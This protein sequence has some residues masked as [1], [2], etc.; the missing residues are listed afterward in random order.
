MVRCDLVGEPGAVPR[1]RRMTLA[2]G[3]VVEEQIF[4]QNDEARRLYCGKSE[5]AGSSVSGYIAS[6]YVDEI[7]GDRCTMHISSWFD[8]RSRADL[9][10]AA[11]RFET[12]YQ[13]IF[14]GFRNYFS[15]AASD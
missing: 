9:P 15:K 14:N 3:I 1:T 10:P 8:V 5:P 4:Y 12:I 13:A 11:A 6:A 2:N 7:D